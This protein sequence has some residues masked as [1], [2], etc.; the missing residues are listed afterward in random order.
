MASRS[1]SQP[2]GQGGT[3][4]AEG[5][6]H[7]RRPG[8]IERLARLCSSAPLNPALR[9]RLK[10]WYVAALNAQSGGRGLPATLPGGEVVRVLPEHGHLGWNPDEYRAF[11]EAAR[12]GMT[13]LD[14]GANVG[15]Y[16][17]LLGQWVG[18]GGSV[19]AFEPAPETYD[20]L[21][22]HVELNQ[23]GQVVHP[24]RAALGSESGTAALLAFGN[25][26]SSRLATGLDGAGTIEVQVTTIDEFCDR[27]RLTPA[28]IK[29]DVEGTELDVLRGARRTIRR[30]RGDLA[31]FVELHPTLW[32]SRGLTRDSLAEEI[33]LQSLTVESIVQAQDP[34]SLEGLCV[35]LRAR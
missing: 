17:L 32:P 35:R 21:A 8:M 10:R 5:A 33:A 15:A 4:I 31:L 24:V 25:Q 28:F 23:L 30:C 12:P 9:S 2:G 11:R 19:F 6:G 3:V 14:V 13:V 20:G 26:G 34:W 27:H 18:A 22:R 16:A 7:Y 29:I 1:V